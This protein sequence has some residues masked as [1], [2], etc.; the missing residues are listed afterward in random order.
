MVIEG[1]ALVAARARRLDADRL[2]RRTSRRRGRA[3]A[4]IAAQGA[5]F[6][7]LLAAAAMFDL[8]SKNF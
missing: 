3:R 6:V 7:A 4:G 5:L 8:H 2:A 1:L